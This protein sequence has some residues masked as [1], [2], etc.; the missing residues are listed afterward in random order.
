M[1]TLKLLMRRAWVKGHLALTQSLGRPWIRVN[2]SDGSRLCVRPNDDLARQILRNEGFEARTLAR[3]RE[4][5]REGMLVL[6]IG[7]NIGYYTVQL[8]SWVGPHG[9]VIAFEPNPTMLRELERNVRFNGLKN[10]TIKPFALSNETGEST[11]YCPPT[12]FEGHGTLRANQTFSS[13]ATIRVATRKLD[14]VLSEM[15]IDS[16]DFIKIDVEGAERTVFAGAQTLLAAP[17]RPRI[18]F[19]CAE[20]LCQAFG[21]CGLDLLKEVE[22]YGYK[23]EEIDHAIWCAIPVE[24]RR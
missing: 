8:A 22:S 21:H 23:L 17:R 11:F 5:V 1:G 14:D 12:G 19:E 4:L 2:L 9:R 3:M 18:I 20:V 10:V 24:D 15:G 16:V 6:D 13:V 7:A